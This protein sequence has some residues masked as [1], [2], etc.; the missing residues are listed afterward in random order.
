MKNLVSG[1]STAMRI[2]GSIVIPR[3]LAGS[4]SVVRVQVLT[5]VEVAIDE[6]K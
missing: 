5:I 6:T 2:A 4:G 1:V 3:V